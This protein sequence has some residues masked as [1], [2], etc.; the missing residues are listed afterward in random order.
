MIDPVK[1]SFSGELSCSG[2]VALPR[3]SQLA[4]LSHSEFDPELFSQSAY[5]KVF[6]TFVTKVPYLTFC[7]KMR[8]FLIWI[9]REYMKRKQD[10]G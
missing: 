10:L 2:S 9:G 1:V 3:P 4:E 6:V 5:D 8:K 7:D